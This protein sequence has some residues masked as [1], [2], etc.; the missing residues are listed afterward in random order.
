MRR[1]AVTRSDAQTSGAV[2][3][4]G[5]RLARTLVIIALMLAVASVA[6]NL[7]TSFTGHDRV[8]GLFPLLDI[9]LEANIPTFYSSILLLLNAALT[10]LIGGLVLDRRNRRAYLGIALIFLY[11]ATDE[12]ARIHELWNGPTRQIIGNLRGPFRFAWVI[13]GM[14]IAAVVIA[15]YLRFFFSLSRALQF[16]LGVAAAVYLAGAIGME[17]LGSVYLGFRGTDLGYHL[18]VTVEET[19][20]MLGAILFI[21]V[22]LGQIA[23]HFSPVRIAVAD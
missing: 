11:M 14:A 12:I 23:T 9:D 19:V 18:V 21:S 7:V 4:P 17:L 3:I 2:T 1:P 6:T 8:F 13:P 10:A 16:R 5:A 15:T 22:W 20:E